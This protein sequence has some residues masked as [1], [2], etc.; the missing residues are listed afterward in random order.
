MAARKPRCRRRSRHI[1]EPPYC[2]N[3]ATKDQQVEQVC[4]GLAFG[5]L[6]LGV[7]GMSSIVARIGPDVELSHSLNH[8]MANG[9]GGHEVMMP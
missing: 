2:R 9:A 7:D 4:E 8:R 1:G 6:A 5:M 3:T